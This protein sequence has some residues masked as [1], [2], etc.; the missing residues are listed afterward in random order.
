MTSRLRSDE[1]GSAVRTD[2]LRVSSSPATKR[3]QGHDERIITQVPNYPQVD[4]TGSK[5]C[6]DTSPD[7]SVT[8]PLLTL[9][10]PK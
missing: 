2:R 4:R 8:L 6:K 5:A 3:S 10:A 1:I 9:I 7:T